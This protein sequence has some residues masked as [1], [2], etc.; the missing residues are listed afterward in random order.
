MFL[1]YFLWY[2]RADFLGNRVF[3]YAGCFINV[4][5]FIWPLLAQQKQRNKGKRF[6]QCFLWYLNADFLGNRFSVQSGFHSNVCFSIWLLLAQQK[7][8][9]KGKMFLH[10]LLWYLRADFLWNWGFSSPS[11]LNSHHL[12]KFW[13]SNSKLKWLWSKSVCFCNVSIYK[14]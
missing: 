1:P 14:M 9:N 13:Y 4:C 8:Q 7:Q 2:L 6:P 3:E 10:C 11:P 12:Y 5:F